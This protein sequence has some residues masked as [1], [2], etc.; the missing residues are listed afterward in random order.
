MALI[1]CLQ[2]PLAGSQSSTIAVPQNR[3][4]KPSGFGELKTIHAEM[5]PLFEPDAAE[6]CRPIRVE[7]P[8]FDF[9]A[10]F[11]QAAIMRDVRFNQG[12]DVELASRLTTAVAANDCEPA[13]HN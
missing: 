5:A 12:T 4:A 10:R 7:D 6:L 2:L 3:F 11:R 13:K 1:I 8:T 9:D